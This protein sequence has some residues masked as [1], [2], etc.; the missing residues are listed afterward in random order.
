M[1]ESQY[2]DSWFFKKINKTFPYVDLDTNREDP[3]N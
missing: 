2:K 1:E 3:S